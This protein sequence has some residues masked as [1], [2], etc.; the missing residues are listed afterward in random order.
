LSV[1]AQADAA[2]RT[3]AHDDRPGERSP[4]RPAADDRDQGLVRTSE[5]L[6]YLAVLAGILIGGLIISGEG[7]N[8]PDGFTA[9]RMWLYA[10][11]LT[12][13]YMVSRGLAKAGS[14]EPYSDD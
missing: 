5:F 13:G 12:A 4:R 8:D 7:A 11:I 3:P 2:T 14:R 9:N 1:S 10:T 6:A